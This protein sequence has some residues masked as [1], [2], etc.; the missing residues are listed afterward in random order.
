MMIG[1]RVQPFTPLAPQHGATGIRTQTSPE[2][3]ISD[4]TSQYFDQLNYGANERIDENK[5]PSAVLYV[6][7]K[8]RTSVLAEKEMDE[9]VSVAPVRL[10]S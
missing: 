1:F 4:V 6:A 8:L 9:Q 2:S 7:G 10:Q 3:A 5:Y